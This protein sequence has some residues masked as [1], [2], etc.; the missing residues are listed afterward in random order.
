MSQLLILTAWLIPTFIIAVLAGYF[1]EKHLIGKNPLKND[2]S[3]KVKY[4]GNFAYWAV[5]MTFFAVYFT[6]SY[7]KEIWLNIFSFALATPLGAF[8][9]TVTIRF[10]S[11]LLKR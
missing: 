10:T 6:L 3:F 2:N 9:S 11:K 8:L 1:T 5:G 4:W 7:P